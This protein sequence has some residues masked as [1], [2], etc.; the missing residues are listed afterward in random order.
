M[1]AEAAMVFASVMAAGASLVTPASAPTFPGSDAK[2]TASTS[3]NQNQKANV[4]GQP[5]AGQHVAALMDS[6]GA[7]F[8]NPG[9]PRKV[10]GMSQECARMVR[11]NRL[12]AHGLGGAHI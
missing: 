12:R 9:V 3:T 1:R 11:H 8:R 5:V 10:W 2:L 4:Q 6:G 7:M